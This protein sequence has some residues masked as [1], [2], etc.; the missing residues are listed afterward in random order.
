MQWEHLV[1]DRYA[2]PISNTSSGKERTVL[3]KRRINQARISMNRAR[4][5]RRSKYCGADDELWP[6][7]NKAVTRQY[8]V[9]GTAKK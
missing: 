3:R 8:L 1:D 7:L 6:Q 2:M 4:T 9:G 5:S